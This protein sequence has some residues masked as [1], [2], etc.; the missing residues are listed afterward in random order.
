MSDQLAV[1]AATYTTHKTQET[2]IHTLQWDLN[3]HYLSNR[4]AADLHLKLHGHRD[5]RLYFIHICK[6]L[7]PLTGGMNNVPQDG[8]ICCKHSF[9]LQLLCIQLVVWL[10]SLRFTQQIIH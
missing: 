2:S 3:T 1:E 7:V 9:D 10:F 4:A 8:Y 5:Q 6:S